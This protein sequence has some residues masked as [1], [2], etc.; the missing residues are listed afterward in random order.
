MTTLSSH[1]LHLFP[2]PSSGHRHQMD[3]MSLAQAG[4]VRKL[5]QCESE[6]K[7]KGLR[8]VEL[9]DALQR[10]TDVHEKLQKE[11]TQC[12]EEGMEKDKCIADL[13]STLQSKTEMQWKLKSELNHL[14]DR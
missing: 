2:L 6:G 1:A 14:E 4:V 10:K 3:A 13:S 8:I 9:A 11:L 12:K 5:T 7:E